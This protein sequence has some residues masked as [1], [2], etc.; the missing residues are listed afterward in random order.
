MKKPDIFVDLDET[1]IHGIY[2]ACR[3]PGQRD[4]IPLSEGGPYHSLLR[5]SALSLLATVR[6]LGTV[7]MLTTAVREYALIHNETYKLGFAPE[8]IFAREDYVCEVYGAYGDRSYE[9]INPG[10]FP[11]AYLLDDRHPDD[12]D[13]KLKLVWLGKDSTLLR[14]P[15]F[16]GK[17]HENFPEKLQKI[18]EQIPRPKTGKKAPPEPGPDIS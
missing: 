2:G 4:V 6:N 5:P 17:D 9:P 10:Q 13:L 18:L 16:H 7:R 12:R 1:L 8:D 3:N 15:A 11:G 14:V